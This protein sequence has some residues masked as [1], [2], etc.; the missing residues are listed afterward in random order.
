MILT[1][2]SINMNSHFEFIE[3]K[4][5]YI[6]TLETN[7]CETYDQEEDRKEYQDSFTNLI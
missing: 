3:E 4:D 5:I 2:Y 6:Y 7:S 1:L